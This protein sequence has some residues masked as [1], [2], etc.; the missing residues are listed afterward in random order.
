MEEGF[1]QK[2][3]KTFKDYIGYIV[4]C[5][6]II[7]GTVAK[8][9]SVKY[10]QNQEW[11]FYSLNKDAKRNVKITELVSQVREI[12][13][14]ENVTVFLFH[15]GGFFS[16]GVPYRKKSPAF[17][18]NSPLKIGKNYKYENVPLTQGSEL[19]KELTENNQGFFVRTSSIQN[20]T[21]KAMLLES[22]YEYNFYT[23]LRIGEKMI[24]YIK[25]SW[26]LEL[27]NAEKQRLSN[28]VSSFSLIISSL[29]AEKELDL[30]K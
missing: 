3:K 29:L 7:L 12:A 18:S 26:E 2:L 15:N 11:S 8:D 10:F 16:S 27:E 6:F 24:G 5:V 1:T 30:F 21:W 17:E 22:G 14:A 9:I 13:N 4:I 23:S 25:I 28:Q 20:G 19:I